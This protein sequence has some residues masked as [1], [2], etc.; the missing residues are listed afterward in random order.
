MTHFVNNMPGISLKCSL[1]L[2]KNKNNNM[3]SNDSFLDGLTRLLYDERYCK[4]ILLAE[5]SFFVAS[6]KYKDYPISIFDTS[7]FWVCVEGKIYDKTRSLL[8]DELIVL[9]RRV[10]QASSMSEEDKN[11]ISEWLLNTDGDFILYAFNKNTKDFVIMNDVLGRLP[12]F[13]HYDE[14]GNFIASREIRLLAHLTDHDKDPEA[15]LDKLGIVELLLFSHTL[16]KRTLLSNIH[17][18]EPASL[19][20]VNRESMKPKI[21]NLYRFNFE[22]KENT[23]VSIK[24]NASKLVSLFSKACKNRA[25]QNSKNIISLSGGFD[26]RAVAAS[27]YRNNVLQYAVTS[28]EPHWR[29]VDGT[30]TEAEIAQQIAAALGIEWEDFG[31]MEPKSEDLNKI[32]NMKM[33]LTYLAHSFLLPFLNEVK[34]KKGSGSINFF[35]GHGG[36]I[37]F[38]D[39]SFETEDLDNL[40]R[41]IIRIK[42]FLPLQKVISLV[43]INEVE[44]IEEIREILSSY[45]EVNLGQKLV[46]YLFFE[47]NVKFSFEIEDLNRYYFWSVA[48]FYSVPFFKYIMNCPDQQKTKL[49][50]YREFLSKI[51]PSI[52]GIKNSN[53][54]CS[55][56]STRF[57]LQQSIMPLYWKY[58]KLRKVIKKFKDKRNYSYTLDS[59]IIRCIQDQ[60]TNCKILSKQLSRKEIEGIVNNCFEYSHYAIDNLFTITSLIDKL[61]CKNTEIEKHFKKGSN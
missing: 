17:R 34:H 43:N 58:T 38:A 13:Y 42:G 41:N 20:M 60:L 39:L 36:D 26:S 35:T 29:P 57:R 24:D 53:W 15:K 59:K 52:A 6:T 50:L 3:S 28:T 45:P 22:K 9:L 32:L 16:G 2:D 48:P 54:G 25:D 11:I 21:I 55:I 31:I 4:E 5:D 10:F 47:S 19:L 30:R 51:S 49:R 18:L 61:S 7:E 14:K 46:H 56:L 27:L 8:E 1:V 44:I 33:G 23:N 40:I 12:F 37:L